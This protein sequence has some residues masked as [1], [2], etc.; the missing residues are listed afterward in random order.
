M[1]WR[2]DA[3]ESVIA[4]TWP[5]YVGIITTCRRSD[6]L[7]E[8]MPRRRNTS[9]VED[10]LNMASRIPWWMDAIVAA[11]S[12]IGLHLLYVHLGRLTAF[13]PPVP[14]SG[15]NPLTAAT[16]AV[17]SA[18][19]HAWIIVGRIFSGVFQY[20]MPVLFVLGGI[21]SLVTNQ[22]TAKK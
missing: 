21:V 6:I 14:K 18:F 12:Y 20:A 7:E 9:L 2:G 10:L 1:R 3:G 4:E 5:L 11:L 17:H 22:W 15:V 13:P 8:A 16:S 19:G